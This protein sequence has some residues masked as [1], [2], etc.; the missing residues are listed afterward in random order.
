[1]LSTKLYLKSCLQD[2]TYIINTLIKPAIIMLRYLLLLVAVAIVLRDVVQN[3][4]SQ[5]L[6]NVT[7]TQGFQVLIMVC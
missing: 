1:M 2:R 6:M 7:P 3:K 5:S 4:E